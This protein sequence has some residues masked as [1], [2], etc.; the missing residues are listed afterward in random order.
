MNIRSLLILPIL[1][2]ALAISLGGGFALADGDEDDRDHEADELQITYS[3]NPRFPVAGEDAECIITILHEGSPVQGLPVSITLEQ[4]EGQ[5]HGHGGEADDHDDAETHDDADGHTEGDD[6]DAD[7]ETHDESGTH[8]DADEHTE[9]DD[10]DA[11]AETHDESGTHDDADEHT[12]DEPK[13]AMGRLQQITDNSMATMDQAVK[14]D[15]ADSADGTIE[16]IATE[17][18]PGVYV[19][20]TAFAQNGSYSGTIQIADQQTEIAALVRSNAVAWPLLMVFAGV[21]ALLA[22]GVAVMKTARKRW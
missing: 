8:D 15:G 7:G 13:Q 22:C 6:H 4:E 9:G 10:H 11:D 1:F 20:R 19:I 16:L 17:I 2:L 5:G 18:E 14:G 3:W 21:P 12:E